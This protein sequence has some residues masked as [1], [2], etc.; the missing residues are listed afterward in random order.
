MGN[1]KDASRGEQPFSAI[2]REDA[3]NSDGREGFNWVVVATY[4]LVTPA[5]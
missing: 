2:L 3:G 5:P 4:R 1:L